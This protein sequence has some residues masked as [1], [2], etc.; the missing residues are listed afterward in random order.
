M[1]GLIPSTLKDLSSLL[2]GSHY[3]SSLNRHWTKQNLI[4]F[5]FQILI[6]FPFDSAHGDCILSLILWLK[7]FEFGTPVASYLTLKI[8]TR[9]RRPCDRSRVNS[10]LILFRSETRAFVS[11]RPEGLTGLWLLI[12]GQI[13]GYRH[14]YWGALRNCI[15]VLLHSI[16]T[17]KGF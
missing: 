6:L 13:F 16:P 10:L 1:S 3:F 7:Y 2:Y 8:P 4:K 5:H 15:R 12:T 17:M 9:H 14:A 11:A